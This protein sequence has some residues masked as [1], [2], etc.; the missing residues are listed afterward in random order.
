MV[1]N[2]R[3]DDLYAKLTEFEKR[4][5][6]ENINGLYTNCWRGVAIDVVMAGF[7]LKSAGG[8]H[9]MRRCIVMLAN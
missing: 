8:V 3:L 7:G 4:R 9:S 5:E 1:E 2:R 6:E